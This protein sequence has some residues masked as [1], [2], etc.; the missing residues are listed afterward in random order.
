MNLLIE[1]WQ[2]VAQHVNE[3]CSSRNFAPICAAYFDWFSSDNRSH[4]LTIPVGG[5]LRCRVCKPRHHLAVCTHIRTWNIVI[6]SNVMPNRRC[7]STHDAHQFITREDARIAHHSSSCTTERQSQQRALEHHQ[8]CQSTKIALRHQRRKSHS[9]LEWSKRI[10]V[11]DA[12]AG[13]HPMFAIIHQHRE[14]NDDL[15][16]RSCENHLNVAWHS[17]H[18]SRTQ[19]ALD[20]LWIETRARR[21]N[22]KHLH[23]RTLMSDWIFGTCSFHF[24]FSCF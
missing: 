10:V 15:V 18:F 3:S 5:D 17:D 24:D 11:L 7:V 23:N 22:V 16:L 2:D 6:R 12:I 4:S 8:H 13:V 14:V 20:H 9:T 21:R 1:V 19:H